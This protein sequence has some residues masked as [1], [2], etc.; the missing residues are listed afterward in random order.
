MNHPEQKPLISF[1][2]KKERSKTKRKDDKNVINMKT[3]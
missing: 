2:E 1:E 3:K